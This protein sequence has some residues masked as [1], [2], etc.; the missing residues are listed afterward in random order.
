MVSHTINRENSLSKYYDQM[1]QL[2]SKFYQDL[3]KKEYFFAE[4]RNIEYKPTS[5]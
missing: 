3:A 1:E 2:E 5:V 4:D